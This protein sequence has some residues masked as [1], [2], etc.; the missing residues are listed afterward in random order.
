VRILVSP[1]DVDAA[2]AAADHIAGLMSEAIAAR[3]WAS[4]ALSGGKT[5]Q[6]MV[7]ALAAHEIAWNSV[8]LFQVDERA[9]P[10]DNAARNWTT[11]GSLVDRVPKGNRH[12]MPVEV[13]DADHRY[14]AQLHEIAGDPPRFDVVHLGVGVDGHTASLVPG[15]PAVGV[16]DR[17]VCWVESYQGNRRLTLT[18]PVLTDARHQVWLVTGSE[19][20]DAV[21]GLI[22]GDSTA[23]SALVINRE[24]AALFVDSDAAS[25]MGD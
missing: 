17:D 5:P 15:D 23:P 10:L 1:S 2:Q 24:T 14:S 25:T 20:S 9:V 19:K 4:L 13:P 16:V 21:S 11:L 12:P 6:T 8:H 18:V 22:S 3:G 7:Q